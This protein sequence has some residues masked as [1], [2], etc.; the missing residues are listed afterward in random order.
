MKCPMCKEELSGYVSEKGL[1]MCLRCGH[2]TTKCFIEYM[3][4]NQ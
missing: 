1:M 4:K 2:I 3:E